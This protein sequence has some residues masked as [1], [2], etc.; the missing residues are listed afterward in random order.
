MSRHTLVL[1]VVVLY[2]VGFR[3]LTLDR[4]FQ[5]DAEG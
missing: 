4:P 3:L 1:A 2:A 5:Y